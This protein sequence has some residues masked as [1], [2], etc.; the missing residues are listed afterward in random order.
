MVFPVVLFDLDGTLTD[1]QVGIVASYRYAL[2]ALGLSAEET[3]IRAC[4]GP[5]LEYNLVELGV[6][7]SE[8]S[9]GVTAYREYFSATGMYEN[10]LYDGIT[11]T[12][13]ALAS[14]GSTLGVA[15][16]K[17]DDFAETILKYFEI[18]HFFAQV[19]GSTRDGRR[20]HKIDV[21]THALEGLGLPAPSTVAMVGD[22]EHDMYAANELGLYAIGASWGYGSEAELVGAGARVLVP[23]PGALPEVLGASS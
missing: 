12:L 8:V 5:P 17:L 6:P 16:S 23:T 2:A 15:T 19:S 9:A 1:S 10:R 11:D 20:A 14:A 3:A 13:A 18:R 21:V 7:A 4:I 22:R